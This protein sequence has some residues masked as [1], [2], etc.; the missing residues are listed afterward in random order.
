MKCVGDAPMS[1]H[2]PQIN[3]QEKSPSETCPLCRAEL[4]GSRVTT[5]KLCGTA[6][7]A[8]CGA[9]FGSG[10]PT[11]GCSAP[12]SKLRGPRRWGP[13]R[14]RANSGPWRSE[15]N[16]LLLLACGISIAAG[17]AIVLAVEK[18]PFLWR[19]KVGLVIGVILIVAGWLVNPGRDA[20]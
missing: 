18:G 6:Y 11:A 5:C 3:V 10:C 13:G 17:A 20:P 19:A 15:I 12:Q 9:E 14:T 4:S 1:P 16:S 2:V 8:Q 7:H